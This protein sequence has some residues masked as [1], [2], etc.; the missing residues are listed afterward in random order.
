M[1]SRHSLGKTGWLVIALLTVILAGAE[2]VVVHGAF[3]TLHPGANDFYSRWAGARALLVEKRDPYNLQ[4]TEEIQA[5]L[6]IDPKEIGRGGFNYPLY[7]LFTFWPIVYLPYSWAQAIWLVTLQ[8]IAVIAACGLMRLEGWRPSPL[9]LVV[10]LL[11]T[12]ALYHV[13]RSILLG[14][15]T[16][17]VLLF[18]A[19]TLL[20][21]ESERDGWAG[22]CL[23]ATA[24]KPQMVILIGPWLVIW[25]IGQRRWRFL[26]GLLAG[27]ATLLL[28]SMALF[29]KWPVRFIEDIFRYRQVAGGQNPLALLHD[30]LWP[31]GPDAVRYGVAG[32]LVL[33]MLAAWWRGW[34]QKGK[35]F[36]QAIYWTLVVSVLVLFQTGTTNQ[37]LL[38]IPWF[39]WLTTAFRR[40][41]KWLVLLVA[42]AIEVALWILFLAT[43]EDGLEHPIMFLPLPL[44]S[45]TILVGTEIQSW[46]SR[47]LRAA[48]LEAETAE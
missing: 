48:L 45:L 14:Q 25:S 44:L 24:I 12:L 43:I 38:I 5:V 19:L 20:A 21:L 15:F 35:A 22:I 46:Y 6:D 32:L 3:T 29:P 23:A 33:A 17:H 40:R 28:S 36:H 31:N 16:L 27:G 8:W 26:G 39:A 18:L 34:R 4:V 9:G 1:I 2:S 41:E 30:L 13:T 10:F 7:V 47:R 11:G 42:G 37:V